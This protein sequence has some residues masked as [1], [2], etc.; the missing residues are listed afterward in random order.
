[1]ADT[2]PFS[3]KTSSGTSVLIQG[4]EC[5]FTDVSLHNICLSSDLG[6]GLVAVG[7]RPTL[8]FKGVHM[9]LGNNL[10]GD[11]VVVD[12]L[13]TSTS[14]VDQPPDPFEQKNPDHNTSCAVTR[15]MTKIAKQNNWIQD[16]NLADTLIGQSFNDE[17]LKSFYPSQSDI[18]TDFDT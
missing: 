7:I 2:L 4:V 5:G 12:Q 1:M 6:T 18:Q 9:L 8:P 10:A 13:L 11:K 17:I 14:C 3:E 15:A 16:I